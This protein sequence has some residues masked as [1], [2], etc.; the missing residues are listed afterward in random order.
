AAVEVCSLTHA[1]T[2]C[3]I[4]VNGIPPSSASTAIASVAVSDGTIVITP[5]AY[6]GLT[7]TDLYTLVPTG[8]GLGAPITSWVATCSNVAFC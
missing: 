2:D 6:K 7:S 5:K 1:M 4:G 8:G 3:D